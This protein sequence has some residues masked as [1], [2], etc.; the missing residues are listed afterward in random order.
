MKKIAYFALIAL[1]AGAAAYAAQVRRIG[2]FAGTVTASR[3]IAFIAPDEGTIVLRGVNYYATNTATFK[4]YRPD[5]ETTA[6]SNAAGVTLIVRSDSLTDST[7]DGVQPTTN[8]SIVLFNDTAG[9]QLAAITNVAAW[10]TNG[11]RTVQLSAS[12]T[13][14]EG[15]SVYLARSANTLTR[16]EAAGTRRVGL[17]YQGVSYFRKP[18]VVELQSTGADS[19]LSGAFEVWF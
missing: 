16:T 4:V 5:K 14:T 18:L 7:I 17:D 9:W 11:L 15:D 13:A 12:V 3:A 2:S 6:A 10:T 19:E 1:V 8:D